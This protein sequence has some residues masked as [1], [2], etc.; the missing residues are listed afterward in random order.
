MAVIRTLVG[1]TD[2]ANTTFTVP[3]PDIFQAGSFRLAWDGIFY[4]PDDAVYGYTEA[5]SSSIQTVTAPPA[6]TVLQGHYELMTS[7]PSGWSYSGDPTTSAKDLVRFLIGDTISTRPLLKDAEILA[8]LSYQPSPAWAAAACAD[9]IANLFS[10]KVDKAIGKT[11]IKLSQQAEAYRKMADR[12]RAGGPGNLPGGDGSGE[13]VGG[14]FVGGVD[15]AEN[16]AIREDDSIEQVSIRIGQDD[17]PG[18]PLNRSYDRE[19][20]W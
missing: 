10:S 18:I 1:T 11:S 5:S 2:G 14:I 8:V 17:N 3:S 4:P 19:R 7:P 9:A 12:L 16:E 20:D 13:R 6:L 15:V